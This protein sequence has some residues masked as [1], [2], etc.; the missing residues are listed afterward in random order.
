MTKKQESY[1]N[2]SRDTLLSKYAL[3]E[4][5]QPICQL[6]SE[7][8]KTTPSTDGAVRS[9]LCIVPVRNDQL[10]GTKEA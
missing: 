7:L 6:K 10:P 1:K 3:K 8:Y 5:T 2:M 9:S 4:V